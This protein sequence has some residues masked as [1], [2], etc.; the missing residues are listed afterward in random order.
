[1]RTEVKNEEIT[2]SER[3]SISISIDFENVMEVERIMYE[4]LNQINGQKQSGHGEQE[5]A[6]YSFVVDHYTVKAMSNG[7]TI[8]TH[9]S[10]LN[11][12]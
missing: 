1:M 4:I 5:T 9:E 12:R 2:R 8:I 3:S 10:K 7:D 6:K 11:E